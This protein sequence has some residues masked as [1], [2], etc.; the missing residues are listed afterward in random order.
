M[1]TTTTNFSF[2]I[3]QSTDLVKDGATAIAALGTSVD[4]Q[5]VD[6]KGGTTGQILAKAS[7]TDLDYSWITNDVG[8]ITAV[9]AGTG[10]S[11][12]GT[13][14]AVTVTNSMATAIDAKGDLIAGTGADAFSR[15]AVG[16]NGTVVQADS[17]AA[18]GLKYSSNAPLGGM[19]LINSGGTALTGAATITISGISNKS[20]FMVLLENASTIT[21]GSY[22]G[23]RLNGA[24]S[25][26]GFT[27]ITITN[28]TTISNGANFVTDRMYTNR[29]GA[30]A[31]D[32]FGLILDFDGGFGAGVVSWSANAISS[33]TN[34]EAYNSKG[35]VT[36]SAQ[37]TS[38]SIVANDNFDA[39]TIYIYGA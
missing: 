6:L 12:G 18:T 31:A 24:A 34:G 33:G 30:S 14:G 10:I 11:G 20:R 7:N 17:T 22:V 19:T 28:G 38:I 29:Q 15:I 32:T 5:F 3:P 35:F 39:G 2:P 8:D 37:V 16:A 36:T 25:G 23:L 9:T 26:Y 1:A 27:G 21:G 4:T 13:S